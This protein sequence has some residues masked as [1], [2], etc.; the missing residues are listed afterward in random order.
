MVEVVPPYWIIE[1]YLLSKIKDGHGGFDDALLFSFLET[2]FPF[3][4]SHALFS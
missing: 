1:K 2:I 4:P 3:N